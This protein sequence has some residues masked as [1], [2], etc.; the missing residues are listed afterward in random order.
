M[1][2]PIA[3]PTQEEDERW[4][5]ARSGREKRRREE[6]KTNNRETRW[7]SGITCVLAWLRAHYPEHQQQE[8]KRKRKG[9]GKK[10]GRNGEDKHEN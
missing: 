6:E 3:I 7:C 9:K 8:R 5:K 2:T 1:V 10:R 4:R